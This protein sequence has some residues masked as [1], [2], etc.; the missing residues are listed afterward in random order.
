VGDGAL[1]D[2]LILDPMG[3]CGAIHLALHNTS[4]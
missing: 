1:F 2:G 4:D 3:F